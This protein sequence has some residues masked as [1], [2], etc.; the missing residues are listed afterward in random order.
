MTESDSPG[1]GLFESSAD[2]GVERESADGTLAD[3]EASPV[4]AAIARGRERGYVTR[5]ELDRAL[6]HGETG[7]ERIEDAMT[8]LSELGIAV[9]ESEAAGEDAVAA[10]AEGSTAA[11]SAA[12]GGDGAG[13]TDDPLTM[14]LRDLGG[15]A[16]LTREGEAALAKRIEAGRRMMLEGLC[17]SLAAMRTVSTWRDTVREG[18][19]ALRDVIDVGATHG[20]AEAGVAGDVREEGDG[21]DGGRALPS[22]ME[23]AVLP[24]V[25]ETLDR[26]AASYPKLRRLEE[27]R[28][29]LAR[30]SG[31]LTV[32]QT[33]RRRVL[34]RDLAASMRSLHLAGA[35]IEALVEELRDASGRLRWCEGA[36]LRMATECGVPREA[37]LE[38]HEGRELEV[39]WLSRVRRLRGE[40][41]KTLA[42]EKRPEVLALRRD[43]LALA[44]E[45]ATE[46]ADLRRI[47][48]MVLAGEHEV[49]QATDEM[50]EANLRLVV[51]IA[52]KYRNRGQALSDLIQEGNTGLMR[53]V[54]KF[55]YRRGFKFSTYATWWIR[56]SMARA[57]SDP[58]PTIRIPVHMVETLAKVKRASWLM[59][60]ELGRAPTPEELS[61]RT[62]IPLDTVR[63]AL[64]AA[65]AAQPVSLETPLGG[66]DGDLRLG[67]LIEDEEAVQPLDAAVASDL[68]DSMSRML[69]SLTPREE[70]VLR[71]RFG[72]GMKSEH[73]L[74]EIGRQ[75]SVT[76]E[77]IRQ[78]E[79]KAL[80]KMKQHSR[81]RVLCSF[82]DR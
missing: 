63:K 31:S 6:P 4:S 55:D 74:E 50:V 14:Y 82:L 65:A 53:A 79:N 75:F 76:R 26:I 3:H 60:R 30:K 38:Q 16:L 2:A 68:R 36:L 78:I 17:E 24:G 19:L 66:D 57:I 32:S 37:F 71:M 54:G 25:M 34:Q 45:T 62:R 39:A 70:R 9:V 29:E 58:G 28:I 44:R 35:R 48:A 80:V 40:G 56:Q 11:A 5:D 81:A 27:K 33:R 64:K 43:I 13:R 47:A 69:G 21:F 18:S 61:G 73:T 22:A 46:P 1:A 72:I 20:G 77:R 42:T 8:V 15:T 52:K 10:R 41:W 12:T 23:A 49:R 51:S 7:A 67:D 59:R